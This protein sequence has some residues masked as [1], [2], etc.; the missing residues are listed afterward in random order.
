MLHI[1]LRLAEATRASEAVEEDIAC[2]RGLEKEIERL[3]G[4]LQQV[5]KLRCRSCF[6]K[7]VHFTAVGSMTSFHVAWYR[8]LN[9]VLNAQ[10][11]LAR[12]SISHVGPNWA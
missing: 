5:R 4:E 9:S 10:Q 12:L 1:S 7:P 6:M 8:F 11:T 2:R 3:T